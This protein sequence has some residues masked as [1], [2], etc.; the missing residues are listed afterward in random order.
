[1][2]I[3]GAPDFF[4]S[5]FRPTFHEICT[6]KMN[7][8]AQ[9]LFLKFVVKSTFYEHDESVL[10]SQTFPPSSE[11]WITVYGWTTASYRLPLA[12]QGDPDIPANQLWESQ[13]SRQSEEYNQVLPVQSKPFHTDAQDI[14]L[15]AYPTCKWTDLQSMCS[16]Q[17]FDFP[18]GTWYCLNIV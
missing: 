13:E 9:Y 16:L 18:M 10:T 7:S 5:I 15:C 12:M 2:R 6:P 1:M 14:N 11:F 3:L 17:L 4:N 8:S